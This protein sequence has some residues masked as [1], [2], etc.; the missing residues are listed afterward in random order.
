MRDLALQLRAAE[1]ILQNALEETA[2]CVLAVKQAQQSEGLLSVYDLINYSAKMALTS[3]KIPGLNP[4]EPF[5]NAELFPR[6]RIMAALIPTR[7]EPTAMDVPVET[8]PY[9]S[10]LGDVTTTDAQEDE[11]LADF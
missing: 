8:E 2:S 11:E 6:T 9:V 1:T 4:L 3:G 7:D 10:F 5:P